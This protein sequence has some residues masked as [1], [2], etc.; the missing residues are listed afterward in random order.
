METKI[1]TIE[2]SY[3]DLKLKY[4]TLDKLPELCENFT[5]KDEQ[6]MM[7]VQMN[8]YAL[9]LNKKQDLIQELA[10]AVETELKLSLE[11]DHK[12]NDLI[13]KTKFEEELDVKKP[14]VAMKD[15]YMMEKLSD[16]ITAKRI[17]EENTKLLRKYL[18]LVDSRIA[19]ERSL[20][21]L[22]QER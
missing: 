2:T 8:N 9:L 5:P 1:K 15:A 22:R 7:K 11:Y 19:F 18:D 12:H 17:A 4:I 14:T 6:G 13:L 3:D 21:Q 16:L 20:L 10:K